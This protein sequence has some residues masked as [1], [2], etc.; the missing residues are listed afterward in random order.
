MDV[1]YPRLE[2]RDHTVAGQDISMRDIS[3]SLVQDND[4]VGRPV[5]ATTRFTRLILTMDDFDLDLFSLEHCLERVRRNITNR[6]GKLVL[7][8]DH[9]LSIVDLGPDLDG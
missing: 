9:V 5:L 2:I 7:L 4:R 1:T 6:D 8:L 3:F